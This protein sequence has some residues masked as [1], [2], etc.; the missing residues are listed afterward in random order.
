[1]TAA[2]LAI[3]VAPVEPGTSI[4]VFGLTLTAATIGQSVLAFSVLAA[5]SV[6]RPVYLP[7]AAFFIANTVPDLGTLA[8]SYDDVPV[9]I[10]LTA[11][12][13]PALALLGPFLWMYVEGLTAEARWQPRQRHLW[14]FLPFMLGAVAAI[15]IFSLP[16]NRR[17]AMLID[18][19]DVETGL[20]LTAALTVLLFSVVWLLQTAYYILRVLR[21]LFAYRRR[22][23]DVFAST[24]NIE[25][26][27]LMWVLFLLWLSWSLMM[28]SMVGDFFFDYDPVTVTLDAIVSFVFVWTLSVW[29]LRQKPGFESL[30]ERVPDIVVDEDTARKGKYERSALSEE[31]SARIASKIERAMNDDR[32]YANPNLSLRDLADHLRVSANYVSQ[33]LNETLGKSFFDY[34]NQWR[35][36]AAKPRVATGKETILNIAYDVGFNSRSS[37]YKAFKAET[38]QTPTTFRKQALH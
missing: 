19:I 12:S 21:R 23:K 36:K 28:V 24:D 4:D 30:Y 35:I 8:A 13:M 3:S 14:H 18:G 17:Y 2:R 11:L 6:S 9:E 33:T 10:A 5:R 1:L 27:W 32:L 26:G 34:V 37:F 16:Y 7:L 38:G 20:E 31:Q 22:V 29:G 25:L 15:L